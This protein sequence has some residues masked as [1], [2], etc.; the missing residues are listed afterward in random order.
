[1]IA[2]LRLV[3]S[4]TILFLSFYGYSQ[5]NYWQS[6]G[7]SNIVS[8]RFNGKTGQRYALQQAALEKELIGIN[9]QEGNEALVYFPDSQGKLIPFRVRETPVFAPALAK[10]YPNIKSYSGYS[11]KNSGDKVRFSVSHRGIQSMFTYLDG[12]ADM[13]LEKVD[14]TD[15]HYTLYQRGG[16]QEKDA[17]FICNTT[18]EVEK[19]FD[20]TTARLVDDQ[21]LRTYR[22]AVSTTGE[23]TQFHGGT[24][25]DALA[26]I[27]ATL[28]R[29]NSVFEVDLGVRL[30]L[31]GD[32]DMLIYTDG[33]TDPYT[34][35]LNAQTQTTLTNT[36]GEENYDVGHLFHRAANN[37][38]AGFIGSV[39]FDN[40]KGSAFSSGSSP[41]GDQFDLD[42]VGHELGHQ[43]GAN[44]TWSFA[45]EG[46]G[47]QAEPGS[48]TTIMGYAGI[49]RNN[50]I[51]LQGDDYF[52]YYS[53]LQISE[54]LATTACGGL[55]GLTNNPPVVDPL[56]N[57]AIPMGTA[58][59]LEA[60][61]SDVDGDMLSFAW[62]QIDNGLVTNLT[63]GPDNQGGAN[64]RSQRPTTDPKRYFPRLSSVLTGDLTQSSPTLN[65]AWETV[66]NIGREMNFAVTVRDN[67]LGGGQVVSEQLNIN[68]VASAGPFALTS[69]TGGENYTA[70]STQTVL[71][72]V[73]NTTAAPINTQT[74]DI[75]L[76]V[77]GGV[78]FSMVLATD[79]PNDGTHEVLIPGVET[80]NARLMVRAHDNV[81]FA[82]N[83]ADFAISS[84]DVV[85]N[86]EALEYDICQPNDTTIP[87]DYETFNGFAE[88]STLSVSGVPAGLNIAFSPS[89]VSGNTTVNMEITNVNAVVEGSYPITITATAPSFTKSVDLV[90]NVYDGNFS[91]VVLSAPA[92]GASVSGINQV[93]QWEAN[94]GSTE[95]DVDIATDMAFANIIE[96]ATVISNTY[97]TVNLAEATSYYWRVRPK[98]NCSQGVFGAAFRF[99][100]AS[101]NCSSIS[102]TDV[103][104]TISSS[105]TS[106]VMAS[107]NFP[108]DR[109]VS[110]VNV[111]LDLD[112]SFVSDLTIRLTSP[113]GT[114]VDL[115]SGSCGNGRNISATF[116]DAGSSLACTN[117][118]AITGTV[119]PLGAL[120]NFNGESSLGEWTLTIND[121]AN[122]DGGTLN[123]FS[124][125]ICVE[126]DVRPD[127]DNDGVLDD[128]DDLCLGTPE[129]V[130]VDANGCPVLRFPDTNFSTNVQNESSRDA[131]D[132]AIAINAM[133]MNNYSISITGNGVMVNDSFSDGYTLDNLSAGTYM[134]CINAE[135]NGMM[136]EESCFEVIVN[137]ITFYPNP[138]TDV[139]RVTIDSDIDAI[140]VGIFNLNG[141]LMNDEVYETNNGEVIMDLSALP[142]GV[143]F[144]K[145][146]DRRFNKTYKVVRQ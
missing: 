129:G 46:T 68:V 45:S 64:F 54:Y 81:F 80:T 141:R 105:G 95:Y 17:D 99:T 13:F 139:V 28:T 66:S 63:F 84:A 36:I 106:T 22:I 39:C 135:S 116:D 114:S 27:N 82:V 140:R 74:V 7:S 23:Y 104:V 73:A 20:G 121:T 40:R 138:T 136:F 41:Q 56:A 93:L 88:T 98:N 12:K 91:E 10:K 94:A 86:F 57:Y 55:I 48:G 146:E 29:V 103:P 69:Q 59:V 101:I 47:V 89:T 53:I 35:N 87:F 34:N 134:V 113:S 65:S 9:Q 49:A 4:I 102:S 120:A 111:T 60:T 78:D 70:G 96:T 21:R 31:I 85:L 117:N 38:D 75:L 130:E 33:A 128:G 127:A 132:G 92:N 3:F 8:Q 142:S 122:G 25:A 16:A 97:T 62:E 67:A 44:H 123:A 37:G 14:R 61:A 109:P 83:A 126:G 71:W 72:D 143:Y 112:H 144:L 58:F 124:L 52:H 2:K 119:R 110:D 6:E 145:F 125:E 11:L 118:P 32:N 43:F 42:F 131:N 51:A 50:N 26:A 133:E 107:V 108:N 5:T 90:L 15:T 79:V 1:M 19:S 100:T 115:V 77:N 18:A 24:V 137:L 76:S 30:E